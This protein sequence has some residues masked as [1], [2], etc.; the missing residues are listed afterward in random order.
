VL[1]TASKLP[2]NREPQAANSQVATEVL[3]EHLARIE[4]LLEKLAAH[5]E[6]KQVAKEY[7][8]V[9]FNN[10]LFTAQF[11]PA[12]IAELLNAYAYKGW[13]V[14][15]MVEF[16]PPSL[17]GDARSVLVVLERRR[18][19]VVPDIQEESGLEAL[20]AL[21]LSDSAERTGPEDFLDNL[22]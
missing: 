3:T 2:T 10:S 1:P 21:G 18:S 15:S 22:A 7:K 11:N 13:T 20:E 8:V 19:A 9:V 14:N 4:K 16:N 6:L 12:R 5:F 17:T